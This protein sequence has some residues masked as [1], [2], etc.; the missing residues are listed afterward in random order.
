MVEKPPKAERLAALLASVPGVFLATDLPAPPTPCSDDPGTLAPRIAPVASQA[1]RS[2][3]WTCRN[4]GESRA[5]CGALAGCE[6]G[7][8]WSAIGCQ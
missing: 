3:L 6:D 5:I 7:K 2:I 8:K 1:V 4:I